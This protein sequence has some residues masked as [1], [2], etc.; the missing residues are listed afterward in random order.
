[1][2]KRGDRFIYYGRHKIVKG[3]VEKVTE[4]VAFDLI[5]GVKIIK[6]TVV[7]NSGEKFEGELCRKIESDLL[8][9]FIRR[10]RN[11]I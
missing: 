10:L 6:I 8:P 5:N 9:R 7:S 4:K 11:I 1:M 3:I 2:L